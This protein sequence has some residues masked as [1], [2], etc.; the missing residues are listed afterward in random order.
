MLIY[1]KIPTKRT[2]YNF[3]DKFRRI[4][5]VANI[6]IVDDSRVSR[7]VLCNSLEVLGYTVVAEA[8]SGNEALKLYDECK[9]DLVTMDITMPGMDGFE[10]LSQIMQKDPSAK[11]IMITASATSEKIVR[12]LKYGSVDYII[13]P[14][15]DETLKSAIDKHLS[16]G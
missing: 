16:R 8:G 10:C 5:T 15:D 6:M 7:K 11:V 12:A 4:G 14:F 13:K 1:D 3:K 2:A 9:P